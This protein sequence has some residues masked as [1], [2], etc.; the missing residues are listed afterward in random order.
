MNEL[1]K[2]AS[3]GPQLFPDGMTTDQPDRQVVGEIVR[4]KLLLSLIHI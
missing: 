4:E 1:G 2:Y 3:E